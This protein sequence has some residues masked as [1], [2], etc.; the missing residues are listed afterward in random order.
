MRGMGKDRKL[1]ERERDKGK[2]EKAWVKEGSG[3]MWKM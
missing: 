3:K 2:G 1:K